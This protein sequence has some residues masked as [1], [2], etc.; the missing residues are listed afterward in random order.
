MRH[1]GTTGRNW[2]FDDVDGYVPYSETLLFVDSLATAMMGTR[3]AL[4]EKFHSKMSTDE[5]KRSRC[6]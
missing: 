1:T 4:L 5:S 2:G 3:G 6:L